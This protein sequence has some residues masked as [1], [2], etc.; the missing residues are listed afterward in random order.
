M[1]TNRRRKSANEVIVEIKDSDQSQ[2]RYWNLR[3][4]KEYTYQ[5][6]NSEQL[7]DEIKIEF[8]LNENRHLNKEQKQTILNTLL[9]SPRKE[10]K[11]DRP[12]SVDFSNPWKTL[13]LLLIIAGLITAL[14][15]ANSC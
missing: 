12:V 4:E 7:N 11:K 2:Q 8:N 1:N 9:Q 3:G 13:A 6:D 14:V 10:P 5:Q 15:L